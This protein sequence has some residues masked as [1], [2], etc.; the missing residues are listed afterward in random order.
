MCIAVDLNELTVKTIQGATNR[1]TYAALKK[2]W[3]NNPVIQYY[4]FP[5]V[6]H[7]NPFDELDDIIMIQGYGWKVE[8]AEREYGNG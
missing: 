2:L 3:Y 7:E 1:D 4:E 6:A 8:G 5:V